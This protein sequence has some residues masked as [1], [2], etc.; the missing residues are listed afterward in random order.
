MERAAFGTRRDADIVR[1]LAGS[2]GEPLKCRNCRICARDAATCHTRIC[3]G[4]S[5][6]CEHGGHCGTGGDGANTFNISTAAAIVAAAAER[7]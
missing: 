3:G 1:L 2:T 7:A 4:R 5:A 6:A